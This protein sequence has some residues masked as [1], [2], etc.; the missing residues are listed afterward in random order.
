MQHLFWN[1][2]HFLCRHTVCVVNALRTHWT[3]TEANPELVEMLG[4]YFVIKL[5][6]QRCKIPHRDSSQLF[7]WISFTQGV[8]VNNVCTMGSFISKS[9]VHWSQRHTHSHAAAVQIL[10]TPLVE[11]LWYECRYPDK[12]NGAKVL[13]VIIMNLCLHYSAAG[14]HSNMIWTHFVSLP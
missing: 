12:V 6:T 4:C 8:S 9:V 10:F 1:F 5:F 2:S 14:N 13:V 7:H 3:D 11:M